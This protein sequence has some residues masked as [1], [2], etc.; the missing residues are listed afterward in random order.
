[1][2]PCICRSCGRNLRIRIGR[3]VWEEDTYEQGNYWQITET[4]CG[5]ICTEEESVHDYEDEMINVE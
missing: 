3:R 5:R 4:K 1:V 2:K